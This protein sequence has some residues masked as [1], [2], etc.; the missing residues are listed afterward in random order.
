M[1]KAASITTVFKM[2]FY[3]FD[4]T[5]VW[6]DGT[7]NMRVYVGNMR[8]YGDSGYTVTVQRDPGRMDKGP[9]GSLYFKGLSKNKVDAGILFTTL[10]TNFGDQKEEKGAQI[11]GQ[12]VAI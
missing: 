3:D 6:T 8:Y 2:G 4:G 9:N 7:S 10:F 12:E 5:E 1:A 11:V